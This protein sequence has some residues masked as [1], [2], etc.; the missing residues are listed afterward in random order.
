MP[1]A[2]A[3]EYAQRRAFGDRV[4]ALRLQAGHSQEE[5]AHIAGLDRTYVGSVERGERNV[6]LDNIYRLARALDIAA[7][8]LLP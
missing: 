3:I 2:T 4:R 1:A 8:D 5:F 6:S 7:N